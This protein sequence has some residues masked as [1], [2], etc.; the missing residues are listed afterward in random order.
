VDGDAGARSTEH[1]HALT[2]ATVE[3]RCSAAA[4]GRRA[5]TVRWRRDGVE[6]ADGQQDSRFRTDDEEALD[7]VDVRLDDA[8]DYTCH[9]LDAVG[10]ELT[11]Q[12]FVVQVIGTVSTTIL[13]LHY[14]S[15]YYVVRSKTCL[16]S[17]IYVARESQALNFLLANLTDARPLK[18]YTY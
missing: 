11:Q 5:A 14:Q 7:I 3:L 6:V 13:P 4:A 9:V 16:Y 17:A 10:R 2:G 8:G 18:L 15:N 12:R 1:V